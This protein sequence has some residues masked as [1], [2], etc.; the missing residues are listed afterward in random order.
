VLEIGDGG[1]S[2]MSGTSCIDYVYHY[3]ERT[4]GP[5]INK[6]DLPSDEAKKI[7]ASYGDLFPTFSNTICAVPA[8]M[9]S[10]I[11]N[12]SEMIA[13]EMADVIC[14]LPVKNVTK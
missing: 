8:L 10:P 4:V 6:S 11:I 14:Q 2:N 12:A 9:I 7:L 1:Y 5:F 3:Y 13:H